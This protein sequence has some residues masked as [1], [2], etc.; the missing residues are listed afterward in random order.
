MHRERR[1][2]VLLCGGAARWENPSLLIHNCLG[3]GNFLDTTSANFNTKY[4]DGEGNV[5]Q[6]GVDTM[7]DDTEKQAGFR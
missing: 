7:K 6:H 2:F 1:H 5:N 4:C 3:Y